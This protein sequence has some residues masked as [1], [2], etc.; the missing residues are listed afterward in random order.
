MS[1]QYRTPVADD[2][3]FGFTEADG[4]HEQTWEEKYQAD[5]ATLKARAWSSDLIAA[6]RTAQGFFARECSDGL[7]E[8]YGAEWAKVLDQSF[9][10]YAAL[11]DAAAEDDESKSKV[12]RFPCAAWKAQT[13]LSRTV[14][15]PLD[16]KEFSRVSATLARAWRR[17][18]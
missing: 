12:R 7:R 11:I 10:V 4:V 3:P 13:Y 6:F 1:A 9:K 15:P 17:R 8:A 18:G 2:I 5:E 14:L 16:E